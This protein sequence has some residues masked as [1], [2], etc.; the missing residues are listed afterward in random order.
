M[1]SSWRVALATKNKASCYC[2]LNSLEQRETF[3]SFPHTAPMERFRA[4]GGGAGVE[5]P[6]VKSRSPKQVVFL[7]ILSI[8]FFIRFPGLPYMELILPCVGV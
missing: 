2:L 3:C 5:E 1:F 7:F 6:N 8:S 4:G